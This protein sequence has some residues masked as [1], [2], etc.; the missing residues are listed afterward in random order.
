MKE[1]C[2]KREK[3]VE[4]HSGENAR[5]MTKRCMKMYEG[6]DARDGTKAVWMY[7]GEDAR[8]RKGKRIY[9]ASC[10]R[11]LIVLHE[12]TRIDRL[13]LLNLVHVLKNCCA[14]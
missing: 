6:R 5:E 1:I 3:C 12:V 11:S 10:P 9:K 2:S 7:R 4:I 14:A 8:D 13:R